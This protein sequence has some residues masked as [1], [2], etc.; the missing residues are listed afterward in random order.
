MIK[1][2]MRVPMAKKMAMGKMMT[3]SKHNPESLTHPP[4][5]VEADGN[6]MVKKLKFICLRQNTSHTVYPSLLPNSSVSGV[7]DPEVSFPHLS[8]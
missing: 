8:L 4:R 6:G 3:N 1:K 7:S 2:A 5:P